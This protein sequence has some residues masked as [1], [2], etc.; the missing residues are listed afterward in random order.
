MSVQIDTLSDL[1]FD[2]IE[3]MAPDYD[4]EYLWLWDT[5]GENRIDLSRKQLEQLC[6]LIR[7]MP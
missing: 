5:D 3:V 4:Q 7:A 6:D 1:G 2:D